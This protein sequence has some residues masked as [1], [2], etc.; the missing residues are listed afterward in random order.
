MHTFCLPLQMKIKDYAKQLHMISFQ[1]FMSENFNAN[2]Y[3]KI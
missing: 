3:A 1:G 2:V